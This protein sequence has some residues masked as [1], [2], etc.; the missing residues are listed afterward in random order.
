MSSVAP[1]TTREVNHQ[2]EG[3]RSD[4]WPE[5]IS[6]P[7]SRE[8]DRVLFSQDGLDTGVTGAEGT[9]PAS[10]EDGKYFPLQLNIVI[11]IIGS[12]GDI[13]PFVAL[14][15][16]L[17]AHGHRVRLATHLA[18]RDFVNESDLEFFDI[19]GDPAELMAFMVKNPGLIPDFKTIRSGAIQ[20]RRREMNQIIHGCWKSCFE[21][22]D[23]THLHQIKED[24]WSD[25]VDYRRRSFVADAIIANPQA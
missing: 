7:Y 17:K 4:D 19:G 3:I 2:D 9:E 24:P 21:T 16:E 20:K 12:R 6:Q 10:K 15:K 1:A 23:G 8:S 14:G 18:F 13:Q 5:D 22:G 11:Q 25:S